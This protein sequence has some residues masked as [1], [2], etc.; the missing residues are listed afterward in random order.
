[1]QT[2]RNEKLSKSEEIIEASLKTAKPNYIIQIESDSPLQLVVTRTFLTLATSMGSIFKIDSSNEKS[3]KTILKNPSAD[4][5]SKLA[6][7]DKDFLRRDEDDSHNSFL[8]KNELGVEVYLNAISGL[9]VAIYY[10]ES[11]KIILNFNLIPIVFKWR[12][13]F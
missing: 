6:S 10:N 1:M 8:I 5:H 12:K 9:K 7:L 13:I 2:D 11:L 3:K 4:S